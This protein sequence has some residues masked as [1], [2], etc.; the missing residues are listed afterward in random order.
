MLPSYFW[1]MTGS[2]W[3][4]RTWQSSAAEGQLP[5]SRCLCDAGRPP[6]DAAGI[7][8]FR[9][10]PGTQKFLSSWDAVLRRSSNAT[11]Q[12]A[13]NAVVRQGMR[14]LKT[15]PSNYRVF[16]GMNGDATFGVLPLPGFLNGH[17]YFVQRLHEVTSAMLDRWVC[18]HVDHTDQ[19]HVWK[20][21][22]LEAWVDDVA[23]NPLE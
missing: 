6:C 8:Y 23:G 21:Y 1:S 16:Y 2:I 9:S 7:L 3:G 10:S 12:G 17:G 22:L 4:N 13:F 14:P 20:V 18:M 15:H 19:H 5:T 11:E